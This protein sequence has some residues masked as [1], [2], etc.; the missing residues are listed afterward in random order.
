QNILRVQDIIDEL[1]KRLRSIKVQAGKARNYQEYSKRLRE[2]RSNFALAE[3]HRLF[4]SRTS[5]EQVVAKFS[6][7]VTQL[8]T[9]MSDHDAFLANAGTDLH[10]IEEQISA[11]EA[12]L[13][14]VQ[15]EMT[16]QQERVSGSQQ[17]IAEQTELLERC[18]ARVAAL[19]Q[20]A[21]ALA[22]KIR[23]H[24]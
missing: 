12:R 11:L 15:S 19:E 2:L 1:E 21:A 10:A 24:D 18:R 4:E 7:A 5:L 16:G 17:R 9:S 14:T 13:L 22:E 8:R 23:E 6:D 3:Y 20:Q